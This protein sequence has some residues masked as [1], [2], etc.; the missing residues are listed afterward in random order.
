MTVIDLTNSRHDKH[1]NWELLDVLFLGS[2]MD[3]MLCREKKWLFFLLKWCT[4]SCLYSLVTNCRPKLELNILVSRSFDDQSVPGNQRMEN[5]ENRGSESKGK[6]E[7]WTH[8]RPPDWR[9]VY[10][11]SPFWN[12]GWLKVHS[13]QPWITTDKHRID[14]LSVTTQTLKS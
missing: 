9:P 10:I 14:A 8:E 3:W 13:C 11:Y 4:L 12:T 1:E 6:V 2:C 7:R 5:K